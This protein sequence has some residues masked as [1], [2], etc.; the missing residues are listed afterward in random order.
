MS[1]LTAKPALPI[2]CQVPLRTVPLFGDQVDLF[3]IVKVQTEWP[4]G[5]LFGDQVDL[6]SFDKNTW[7]R[8]KGGPFTKPA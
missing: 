8:N 1:A 2:A 6:F 3:S 7:T 5:P 4:S